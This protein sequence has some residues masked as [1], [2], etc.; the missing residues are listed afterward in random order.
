MLEILSSREVLGPDLRESRDFTLDR[1]FDVTLAAYGLDVHEPLPSLVIPAGKRIALSELM[2][3]VL[4]TTADIAQYKEWIGLSDALAA[5]DVPHDGLPALPRNP[6][7][8]GRIVASLDELTAS[9]LADVQAA[10]NHYLWG[11]SRLV[12]SYKEALERFYGPFEAG[13][14]VVSRLVIESGAS[15]AVEGRPAV[16]LCDSLELHDGGSLALYTVTRMWVQALNKLS[17]VH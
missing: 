14:Y 16:L 17:I 11:D 9:E 12:R 3:P 10:A 5:N 4:R 8:K 2:T 7:P 13:V 15:L 6:W 1:S